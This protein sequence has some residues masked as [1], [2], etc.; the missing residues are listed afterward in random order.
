MSQDRP[1]EPNPWTSPP[2]PPPAP[3][4]PPAY[5][6]TAQPPPAY[7]PP[8]PGT[9][10]YAPNPLSVQ[11]RSS[12][13]LWLILNIVSVVVLANLP[14]IVGAIYAAL[15]LGR[16]DLDPVDARRKIRVSKIWFFAGLILGVLLVIAVVI[17]AVALAQSGGFS[18][19]SAYPGWRA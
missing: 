11:A 17:F 15:A 7:G 6:S 13:T 5:G 19:G 1:S 16:A 12:A 9:I 8:P 14:G 3:Q 18:S 2:Q 10:G 4:L